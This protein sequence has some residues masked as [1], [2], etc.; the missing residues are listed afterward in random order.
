MVGRF[1]S[2]LS[3]LA[4][5]R[6]VNRPT[7]D[8][9][10]YSPSVSNYPI[11]I[12]DTSYRVWSGYYDERWETGHHHDRTKLPQLELSERHVFFFRPPDT[13]VINK[14]AFPGMLQSWNKFCFTTG[15]VE[16][17][18]SLPG[19]SRTSGFWPCTRF[20]LSAVL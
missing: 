19:T 7:G 3:S 2:S 1:I 11:S 14:F 12:N 10:W 15:Y 18:M 9:E 20:L 13:Q 4:L 17:S 16:V 5:R 8:L 6:R